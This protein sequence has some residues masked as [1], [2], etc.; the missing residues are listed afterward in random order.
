LPISDA[1]REA[2]TYESIAA[3]LRAC[4]GMVIAR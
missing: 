4:L 3:W 2:A 1:S